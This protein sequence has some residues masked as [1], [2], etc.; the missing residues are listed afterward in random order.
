VNTVSVRA[1]GGYVRSFGMND[2]GEAGQEFHLVEVGSAIASG[3]PERGPAP[4][5]P[6]CEDNAQAQPGT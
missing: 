3:I 6:P 2:P 1:P 5:L 4:A